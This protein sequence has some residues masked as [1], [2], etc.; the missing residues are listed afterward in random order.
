ML[1][2]FIECFGEK[3]LAKSIDISL[4]KIGYDPG[5]HIHH[6]E[7]ERCIIGYI[8]E[9]VWTHMFPNTLYEI[10]NKWYK[11]KEACGDPSG[12]FEMTYG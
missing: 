6:C 2:Y 12:F 8:D 7:N 9:R 3:K 11:I 1:T 4:L 5:E 10:P